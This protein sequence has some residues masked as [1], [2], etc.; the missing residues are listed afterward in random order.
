M[1]FLKQRIHRVTAGEYCI[2]VGVATSGVLVAMALAWMLLAQ[3]N[4]S[5]PLWHDYGGIGQA[6]ER[7]GP[8]N[9]FRDDFHLTTREQRFALFA[10][11]NR[12]IHRGGEGLE[13]LTFEVPGQPPQLL[14]TDAEVIHLRDVA[15]LVG[16]GL[17][18]AWGALVV[19]LL[20]WAWIIWRQGR[21]PSL[22]H[23]FLALLAVVAVISVLVLAI[24]PVRVFYGL[25]D[26]LFPP[27]NPWFFYYQESLMATMMH[28]PYLFGWIALE[29]L[30]FTILFFLVVQGF[31]AKAALGFQRWLRARR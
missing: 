25:H 5:Y 21:L 12:A 29:W 4:F 13:S 16:L 9:Q 24:G 26:W 22:Q 31:A 30:L 18:L 1:N 8:E 17:N 3:M 19:W 28:A 27:D 15:H 14:F 10:G 11:I 23:Q 7:Y 2:A 6:I 20:L